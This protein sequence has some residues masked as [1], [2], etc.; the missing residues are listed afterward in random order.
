VALAEIRK[1]CANCHKAEAIDI[2]KGV[3]AKAGQK[4]ERGRGTPLGCDKCHGQKAHGLRPVKDRQS[5][6]FLDNQIRTC[7][8]CHPEDLETYLT[9][10]HGKGLYESGL[11]VTAVCADCHGP[12][13]IY[14]AADRRSTLHPSKVAKT[15]GRCHAYIEERLEASVHGGG[16]GPGTLAE[17]PSAGGEIQRKPS[18]TA[19]HQGHHLLK[20]G[21]PEFQLQ[22][23]N[24]CGNCHL[25]LAGRYAM[26]THGELTQLG[27]EAAA[28][29]SD[30]HGAHQIRSLDDPDSALAPGKNRLET[31]RKCHVYAVANF[32]DFDPH[33]DYT[34]AARYPT[35]YRIYEGI[36]FLIGLGLVVFLAHAFLWFV[37]SLVHTLRYGRHKTLVSDQ[38]ALVR[39]EP[40]DRFIYGAL[41]MAFMGL[42]LTGLPL[43]YGSQEWAK[44]LARALGGFETAMVWHHFFAVVAIVGFVTHVV[45]GAMR[46]VGSRKEHVPWKTIVFGPDSLVP[47]KRDLQ[48][49]W[50]MTRWFF[51]LGRRPVFEHWTYW[52]KSDYWALW[53][54]A[55]L[56]GLSGLMLWYPNLFC[57]FLPGWI[58]NAAKVIHAQVAL[59]AASFAFLMHF[60]H[61]HFRPEKFPLDSSALLGLVS[62][63]HMRKF[64]PEYVERLRQAGKLDQI[65]RPAPSRRRLRLVFWAGLLVFSLAMCLLALIV[66]ANLGK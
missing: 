49:L 33:A 47:N 6:V 34:D 38:R 52:E 18:C 48:D 56:V 58:L 17:K 44:S 60:F 20:P 8:E 39:F 53:A 32:S 50:G 24:R 7:G 4:D 16:K 55:I 51:G 63:A 15:C 46:I 23:A 59:P 13:G 2:V 3:H 45:R 64:R 14:Y 5:P 31:C 29:C 35:L 28:K 61:T 26:D 22:L 41:V 65:R 12:H 11:M 57:T 10:V 42:V 21:S 27:S 1:S 36:T 54:A 62:E 66:L 40:T 30:C 25:D 9:T 19:C 37:R 43:K